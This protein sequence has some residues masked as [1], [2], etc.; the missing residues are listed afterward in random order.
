MSAVYK[1]VIRSRAR[2]TI[3]NEEPRF[4]PLEGSNRS[5]A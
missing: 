3:G 5:A 2:E 1:D 4:T